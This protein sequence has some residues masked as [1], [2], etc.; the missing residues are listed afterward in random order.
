MYCLYTSRYT[1]VIKKKNNNTI[2]L[3]LYNPTN[4]QIKK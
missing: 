4:I 1:N 2:Q 3:L